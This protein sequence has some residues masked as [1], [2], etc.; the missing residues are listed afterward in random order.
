MTIVI[1]VITDKEILM[2]ADTLITS[3]WILNDYSFGKVFELPVSKM[4]VGFCGD[5]R[6][7]QIVR[8]HADFELPEGD[9]QEVL[10]KHF[11][12]LLREVLKTQGYERTKDGQ[13]ESGDSEM[14]IAFRGRLFKTDVNYAVSEYHAP[15]SAMGVGREV[16]LG[17]LATS[18]KTK[19]SAEKRLVTALEV[20]ERHMMGIRAPFTILK[21]KRQIDNE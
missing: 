13:S 11:V 9:A 15:Y 4:L 18:L 16:A 8:Y 5:A 20:S 3:G 10:V 6:F 12:P 17:S 2:G 7:G 1:G 14:M 19:W 21:H